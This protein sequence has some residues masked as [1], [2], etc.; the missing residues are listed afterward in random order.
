MFG[1]RLSPFLRDFERGKAVT[2]SL[3]KCSGEHC[4]TLSSSYESHGL[5]T[6][7][8]LFKGVFR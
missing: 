7:G 1:T 8:G 6:S 4:E 2:L 5:S 3:E